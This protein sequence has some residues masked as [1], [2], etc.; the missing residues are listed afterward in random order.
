M[1]VNGEVDSRGETDFSED[2]RPRNGVAPGAP[3]RGDARG[4]AAACIDCKSWTSVMNW[5]LLSSASALPSGRYFLST[6]S[7]CAPLTVIPRS[8]RAIMSS[9]LS[10]APL[11]SASYLAKTS[12]TCCA[13]SAA[14]FCFRIAC[15]AAAMGHAAA[16]RTK[17]AG[18]PAAA[19]GT[20][21]TTPFFLATGLGSSHHFRD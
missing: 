15:T 14:R 9:S 18:P 12:C 17:L 10:T 19:R 3:A 6:L 13:S 7:A 16:A 21:A 5:S 4:E 8:D 2:G 11:P 1:T 20:S